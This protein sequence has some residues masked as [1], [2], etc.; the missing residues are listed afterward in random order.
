MFVSLASAIDAFDVLTDLYVYVS[1]AYVFV[2]LVNQLAIS[3]LT[4]IDEYKAFKPDFY[5]SG[6]GSS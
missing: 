1:L 5:F 4:I 6:Q 2:L 3:F